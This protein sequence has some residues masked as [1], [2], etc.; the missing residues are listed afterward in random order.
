[1]L[2]IANDKTKS[3]LLKTTRCTKTTNLLQKAINLA[4]WSNKIN[5]FNF[6]SANAQNRKQQNKNIITL[7]LLHKNITVKKRQLPNTI[8]FTKSKEQ[9]Y[10]LS[11][12]SA[13]IGKRKWQNQTMV[14]NRRCKIKK[15]ARKQLLIKVKEKILVRPLLKIRSDKTKS[16]LLKL[17]L[18]YKKGIVTAR[19]TSK[20][21]LLRDWTVSRRN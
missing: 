19:V 5:I 1:M 15:Q 21:Y 6:G 12:G 11:F 18:I 16:Y 4:Q 13:Y 20:N 8:N 14:E 10:I 9:F 2:K 3:Y 7:A 17:A